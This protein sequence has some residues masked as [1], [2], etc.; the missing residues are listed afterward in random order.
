MQETKISLPTNFENKLITQ[1]EMIRKAEHCIKNIRI[2]LIFNSG[3]HQYRKE[4]IYRKT[5]A[6]NWSA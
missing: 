4:Y 5:S 6:D 3:L 1:L 2:T